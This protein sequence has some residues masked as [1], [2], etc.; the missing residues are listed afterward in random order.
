MR[1]RQTHR[2]RRRAQEFES[3]VAGAGG[4]LL[5]TATLLTTEPLAPAGTGVRAERL[6]CG[7]L[8]R[9][10]AEWDRL[11]GG[12]PYDHTRQEL[13]LRF[14]REAWRHRHP[15]GGVLGRLT[16]LERLVLVLRLYEEVGEDQTAALL[17]LPP[18][19]VRAVCERSMA[20]LRGS[21]AGRAR[22]TAAG[23]PLP[24]RSP[25]PSEMA[26]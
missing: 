13:A 15:L 7:A 25:S 12:D 16:P 11:R 22:R 4:R 17:G 6:L 20:V 26:P 24:S 3:F 19:R 21:G 2:D 23:S 1:E 9:T 5:H 10:Y 8:A 18:D 14:A